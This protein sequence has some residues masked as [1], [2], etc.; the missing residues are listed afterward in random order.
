MVLGNVSVPVFAFAYA[1][2]LA[3]CGVL[4][5]LK[6]GVL[7][8]SIPATMLIRYLNRNN[9]KDNEYILGQQEEQA[10]LL[11]SPG[12]WFYQNVSN[13]TDLYLLTRPPQRRS[14]P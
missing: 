13:S 10:T 8:V 12:G 6:V 7:L 1:Y 2:T 3:P 5:S 14:G 11:H 9:S 4:L